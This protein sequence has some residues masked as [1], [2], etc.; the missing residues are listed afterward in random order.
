M[1]VARTGEAAVGARGAECGSGGYGA[2]SLEPGAWNPGRSQ[3]RARLGEQLGQDA[4]SPQGPAR[5]KTHSAGLQPSSLAEMSRHGCTLGPSLS[6]TR[7]LSVHCV[8][9]QKGER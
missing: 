5:V 3:R 9:Q 1:A 8:R 2:W 7:E 4:A 6:Q